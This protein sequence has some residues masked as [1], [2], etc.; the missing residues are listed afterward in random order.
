MGR[1]IDKWVVWLIDWLIDSDFLNFFFQSLGKNVRII[2]MNNLLPSKVRYHQKFDLKGSTYKRQA[3]AH[4]RQKQV[5]TLKDLDFMQIYPE[6]IFLEPE[7]YDL[8]IRTIRRDCTVLESFKIMDYSLLIGIHNIDLACKEED[9]AKEGVKNNGGDGLLPSE[10]TPILTTHSNSQLH[11]SVS[12]VRNNDL[13]SHSS[14]L[15]TIF[16]G[17]NKSSQDSSAARSSQR[18][19]RK[20]LYHPV[21]SSHFSPAPVKTDRAVWIQ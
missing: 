12:P 10:D 16:R 19:R 9:G 6:G 21:M 7:T 11:G 18:V 17:R 5:P 3:S 13:Q 14:P 8:L 20:L 4:E 2:C 1:L 15:G